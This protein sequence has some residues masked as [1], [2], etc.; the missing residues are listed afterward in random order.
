MNPNDQQQFNCIWVDD[1][2]VSSTL[3]AYFTIV[4]Q[5]SR[6]KRLN[7]TNL[8]NVDYNYIEK[9]HIQNET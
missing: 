4:G 1:V 3:F 6:F 7:A 9:P 5:E 2:L 8:R